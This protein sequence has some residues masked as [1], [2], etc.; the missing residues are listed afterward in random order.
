MNLLPILVVAAQ[1]GLGDTQSPLTLPLKDPAAAEY[2]RG[3]FERRESKWVEDHRNVFERGLYDSAGHLIGIIEV[4]I[5]DSATKVKNVLDMD[6]RIIEAQFLSSTALEGRTLLAYDAAG[7]VTEA[8][9][10]DDA[11]H[12]I[13]KRQTAYSKRGL[14][15]VESVYRIPKGQKAPALVE[16]VQFAY[17]KAGVLVKSTA[18]QLVPKKRTVL[19]TGYGAGGTVATEQTF[20]EWG[21]AKDTFVYA[22]ETDAR[23]LWTKKLKQ[24]RIGKPDAYTLVPVD[25]VYRK[26]VPLKR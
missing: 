13:E 21:E 12:L 7:R 22:Y 24:K 8:T 10:L 17:D 15:A 5:V 23:G 9:Q 19:V 20:D 2:A 3:Y 25:V 16:E 11:G 14:A 26:I 18:T 6:G 1:A 4:G